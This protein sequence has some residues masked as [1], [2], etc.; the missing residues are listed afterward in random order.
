MLG[1]RKIELAFIFT[2]DES[3]VWVVVR[4]EEKQGK[5]QR[6]RVFYEQRLSVVCARAPRLAGAQVIIHS[7]FLV[8]GGLRV[9]ASGHQVLATN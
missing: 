4:R 6:D 2:V 7:R 5:L 8:R 3:W 1:R 9:Y